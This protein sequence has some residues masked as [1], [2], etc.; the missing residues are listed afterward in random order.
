MTGWSAMLAEVAVR[1]R[2]AAQNVIFTGNRGVGKTVLMKRC[3]ERATAAGYELLTI[4]ANPDTPMVRALFEA[5]QTSSAAPG[6]VW[7][8]ARRALA[9]LSGVSLEVA[10]LGAK[11]ELD[12]EPAPATPDSYNVTAIANAIAELASGIAGADGRG[13]VMICIDELQMSAPADL[14]ALGGALNHLNNWA[15]DAPVVFAATGLPNTMRALIGRD[16]EHPLISN[17]ARLFLTHQLSQYLTRSQVEA[18]LR[19]PAQHNGCDWQQAAVAAVNTE[20]GGYP[21]HL[22]VL[23]AATWQTA[24]RPLITADD[25]AAAIPQAR[26]EVNRM[27]ME[28]RWDQATPLQRAY[29]TALAMAGGVARS[30]HV[31]AILGRTSQ[32]TSML[33]MAMIRAG[34]VISPRDGWVALAQPMLVEFAPYA[35]RETYAEN[36]HLP[37]LTEMAENRDTYTDK[38]VKR[39]ELTDAEVAELLHGRPQLRD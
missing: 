27:Y 6:S 39:Q 5:T 37:T 1:G 26:A 34:D 12:P 33:R 22:Q 31:A 19:I 9:R 25:V 29:L 32:Q 13:G 10:K 36:H 28:P 16:S 18:A 15:A 7:D 35:Y 30:G 21:A 20:T 17:P 2:A 11:V 4:Q 14:R 23:A 8:R 24:P 3:A 38:R